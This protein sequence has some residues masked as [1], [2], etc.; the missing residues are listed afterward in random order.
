MP[1]SPEVQALTRFLGERLEG[2]TVAGADLV[3]FRA[4]KTRARPLDS[5]IGRT[6]TGAQRRGKH[7]A[8]HFGEPWLIVSLGRHGWVRFTDPGASPPAPGA[9]SPAATDAPP[10][11]ASL[12]FDDGGVVEFTDAGGWVSLGLS[13]V[14]DPLE[15]AAIAGLGPDPADPA[16]GRS[17]FDAA[18]GGRRKQLKAIL[19]DQGSLAGI[20]NAYSDEI[21]HTARLSPVAHAAILDADQ[22]ARLFASTTATIREAISARDGIP[23]DRLKQAKTEAMRVHG[24]AGEPCPVCGDTIR[25]FRFASATAEYCPTCQTGGALLAP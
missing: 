20:G 4:L 3:E 17:E 5:L 6:L 16:F 12:A 24:R 21:L 9:S 23:I 18:V 8:L 2:R 15:V 1:E 7:V 19:H 10:T 13:V 25:E 11:L 14:D 22:T